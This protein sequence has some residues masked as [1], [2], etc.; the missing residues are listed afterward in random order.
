MRTVPG[1]QSGRTP[2]PETEPVRPVPE[3]FVEAIRPHVSR[4]VWAMVQLQL[5]S[6]MRPG[7]VCCM[8]TRDLDVSGAV[9]IY[10]PTEHKTAHRGRTRTI[11]FGP[12][13]QEI[14][15]EWFRT[16][17]DEPLFQP[18]EAEAERKAAMR[19][20]RKTPV[21]PSQLDRSKPKAQR[22]PRDQFETRSYAHAIYRGCLR[23]DVP[24]WSPNQLR[25]SAAT[26]LR[27]EFGLDVARAVLGHSSPVVTEI[28]AEMDETRAASAMLKIG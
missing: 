1:L 11:Q 9:W 6:G 25:H 17:L 4:Q 20:A 15:R 7:E 19:A 18:R 27:R 28:Y 3:A 24:V 10:R 21:Q 12:R 2:A 8:R 5:L 14:L 22:K 23:A 16:Q 13:A 26:R